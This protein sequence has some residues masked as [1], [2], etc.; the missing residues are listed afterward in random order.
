MISIKY[1][2][3]AAMSVITLAFCSCSKNNSTVDGDT[4]TGTGTDTG[5]SDIDTDYD[6]GP[7]TAC[8][9][10]PPEG[11]MVCVPGGRYLM[12]CMPYDTQCEDAEKPMVEVTLSPF[13]IDRTEVS[14]ETLIPF[15]NTLHEGYFRGAKSVLTEP[16]HDDVYMGYG[17]PVCL[18]EATDKFVYSAY[19]CA[20]NPSCSRPIH[21]PTPKRN[22]KP[23]LADRQSLSIRARM[24]TIR[25]LT[26]CMTTAISPMETDPRP[27]T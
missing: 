5:T 13:W 19:E 6:G 14:I 2:A 8:E 23:P 4:D 17:A 7:T 15:L 25:V 12:G 22:G 20:G 1:P 16:E 24:N 3:L 9:G 27:R 18:N 11:G 26:V 10:D 21:T